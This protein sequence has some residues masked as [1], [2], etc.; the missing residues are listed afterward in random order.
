MVCVRTRSTFSETQKK[1]LPTICCWR[2]KELQA[3][4][5]KGDQ[6]NII[7]TSAA[8]SQASRRRYRASHVAADRLNVQIEVLDYATQVDRRR[9]GL[10][11]I[12]QSV[13]RV[14]IRP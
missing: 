11:I 14:W 13:R 9:S 7:A 2:K 3:T 12:S 10:P 5:Y 4:G 6:I 1:R 8:M